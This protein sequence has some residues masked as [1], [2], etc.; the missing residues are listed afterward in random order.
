MNKKLFVTTPRS[1]H[2]AYGL[3]I[4]ADP[5]T[6]QKFWQWCWHK[7]FHPGW[8]ADPYKYLG[9]FLQGGVT[10]DTWKYIEF[11][12]GDPSLERVNRDVM[13][14]AMELAEHLGMELNI[15]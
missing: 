8:D 3:E 11:L 10:S 4:V 14:I 7:L 6:V 2:M 12:G 13:V 15:K 9:A 1:G 5:E